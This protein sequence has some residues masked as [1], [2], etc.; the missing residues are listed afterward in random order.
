VSEVAAKLK[1]SAGDDGDPIGGDRVDDAFV[2][3]YAVSKAPGAFFCFTS[4]VD[5]HSYDH[6]KPE[7]VREC[8]GNVELYQCS[9]PCSRRLWRAPRDLAFDVDAEAATCEKGIYFRRNNNK[10]PRL[11]EDAAFSSSSEGK[12]TRPAVG[13]VSG[14]ERPAT[15]L[16][17]FLPE[18]EN[19]LQ[20]K[21]F[22][23]NDYPRCP[24][25]DAL[26]RPAILMFDDH[27]WLD[28]ADQARR[29]DAWQR[30]VLQVARERQTHHKKKLKVAI[31]EIG[32]GDNVPT[33]RRETER[34]FDDSSDAIHTTLIRVN[35]DFPLSDSDRTIT[36]AAFT[37]VPIMTTGLNAVHKI[38][39]AITSRRPPPKDD[40]RG[41]GDTLQTNL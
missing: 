23:A 10:R 11:E 17:R 19:L 38:D 22:K 27:D 31:L 14:D 36:D 21:A 4:N 2:E 28:S 24:R 32:A 7:E 20:E 6:F 9:R 30:A 1:T 12:K 5:A 29:Y 35:P 33:V 34:L 40:Q 37:F 15:E 16:L 41:A 26:A 3:A 39:D 25:C 18:A 8:H 13:R